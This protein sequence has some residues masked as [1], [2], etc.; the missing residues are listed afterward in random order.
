M[1]NKNLTVNEILQQAEMLD[2]NLDA[3]EQTAPKTVAALGGRDGLSKQCQ[4]T[5][6]GALPRLTQ[7]AWA[8]M[9]AEY[10]GIRADRSINHGLG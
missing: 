9:S 3:F 6:I 7:D 4:L 1:A 8:A 2:R 10:E 5:C